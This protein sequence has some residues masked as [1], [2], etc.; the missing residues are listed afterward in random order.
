MCAGSQSGRRFSLLLVFMSCLPWKNYPPF[1][2]L[3]L[4]SFKHLSNADCTW[5][6]RL[7]KA[8]YTQ[9]RCIQVDN[10][11]IFSSNN[12]S[13][14]RK[15]GFEW[16]LFQSCVNIIIKGT[17]RRI[18]AETVIICYM[19]MYGGGPKRYKNQSNMTNSENNLR[20]I[21]SAHI[22]LL[23]TPPSI[24]LHSKFYNKCQLNIV[25]LNW[26]Q[27]LCSFAFQV[28]Q[29]TECDRKI[30]NQLAGRH[31]TKTSKKKKLFWRSETLSINGWTPHCD[32][33]CIYLPSI[34][35]NALAVAASMHWLIFLSIIFLHA[36]KYI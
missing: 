28:N 9:G 7:N 35:L 22:P 12:D 4:I 16:I 17:N 20:R 25:F 15:W 34:Q 18:H 27:N 19:C 23:L 24:A 6:A 10:W 29:R 1:L 8:T 33:F 30:L 21:V 32:R 13:G 2:P 5:V 14:S 3:Y 31:K 11:F 26:T 36:G